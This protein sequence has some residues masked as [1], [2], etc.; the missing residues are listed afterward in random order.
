M[1]FGLVAAFIG[2]GAGA[3]EPDTRPLAPSAPMTIATNAPPGMVATP[4]PAPATVNA[5]TSQPTRVEMPSAYGLGNFYPQPT[6]PAE[7]AETAQI[8]STL[9]LP[10]ALPTPAN[11]PTA[12]GLFRHALTK[13]MS[14]LPPMPAPRTLPMPVLSEAGTP[15]GS[16][17]PVPGTNA[18]P[19]KVQEDIWKHHDPLLRD[20]EYKW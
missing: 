1:A 10:V 18:P 8:R 16:P 9:G 12:E 20:V 19:A 7:D 5:A 6:T 13:P 2:T 14:V 17:L 15:T 3:G 4:L 11:A